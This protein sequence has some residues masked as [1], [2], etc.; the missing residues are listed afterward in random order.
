M[1]SFETNNG[2][3]LCDAMEGLYDEE[4]ARP[5]PYC[6]CIISVID[7]EEDTDLA[8]RAEG[9]GKFDRVGD[10]WSWT[11]PDHPQ[12]YGSDEDGDGYGETYRVAGTLYVECC[13]GKTST[14]EEFV[15][16]FHWDPRSATSQEEQDA[17]LEES[18]QQAEASISRRALELSQSDCEPCDQLVS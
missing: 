13:D 16:E 7:D 10:G 18:L 3:S 2:C 17:L 14:G 6:R 1:Y 5:H 4:P 15:L 8:A 9:G 11:L 12:F